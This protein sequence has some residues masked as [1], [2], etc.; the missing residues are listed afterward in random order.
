MKMNKTVQKFLAEHNF[1]LSEVGLDGIQVWTHTCGINVELERHRYRVYDN[2]NPGAA[3]AIEKLQSDR[4]NEFITGYGY[5]IRNTI[6]SHLAKAWSSC[7][8]ENNEEEGW[9]WEH[10][11]IP[12]ALTIQPVEGHEGYGEFRPEE[13]K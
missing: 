2:Y 6:Y 7:Y 3:V 4:G 13:K 8:K 12:E 5:E 11:L 9:F 1:W 10:Y